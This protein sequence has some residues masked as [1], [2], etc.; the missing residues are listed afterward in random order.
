MSALRLRLSDAE[1][2]LIDREERE[3]NRPANAVRDPE[4]TGALLERIAEL[5]DRLYLRGVLLAS[6]LELLERR[7]AE[8]ARTLELVDAIVRADEIMAAHDD[9]PRL[10][11]AA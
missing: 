5:E 7:A 8:H 3:R 11:V 10:A 6:A 2:R 4:R 1:H 9:R